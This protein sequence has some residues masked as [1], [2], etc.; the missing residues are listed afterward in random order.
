MPFPFSEPPS[1]S[2]MICSCRT[3]YYIIRSSDLCLSQFV[4]KLLKLIAD[5]CD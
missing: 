2:G 3:S 1:S 5:G 4:A